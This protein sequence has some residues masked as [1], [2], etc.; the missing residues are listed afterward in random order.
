VLINGADVRVDP[1]LLVHVVMEGP[2]EVVE[3]VD[4][5]PG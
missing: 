3:R 2:Q 5:R 1:V 4:V